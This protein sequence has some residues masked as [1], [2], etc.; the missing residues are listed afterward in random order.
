MEIIAFLTSSQQYVIDRI[1][2][3]L[4][5]ETVPPP[6][7]GPPL[8]LQIRQARAYYD[9]NPGVLPE[10]DLDEPHPPDEAYIV[11]VRYPD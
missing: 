9:E 5:V 8:W 11:D 2:A 3:H 6:S 7:T 1:L 10:D 4:G